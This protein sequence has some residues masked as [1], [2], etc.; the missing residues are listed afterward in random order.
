L[1]AVTEAGQG[2]LREFYTKH[3]CRLKT[4]ELRLKEIRESVPL[5][6]DRAVISASARRIKA[7]INQ[8]KCLIEA[9]EEFDQEIEELFAKHPDHDLFASFPGAGKVLAPRLSAAFGTDRSRYQSADDVQKLSGVAP[10]TNRSGN[11][12]WVHRRYARPRFLHQTFVEFAEQSI[13]Q[14]P[15]AN[16]FYKLRRQAGQEHFAILRTLAFKWQRII[17]RCW[18][19]RAPYDEQTYQMALSRAGSP[20]SRAILSGAAA[21]V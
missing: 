16:A 12:I 18:I 10:V 9:I 6:T 15:W 17:F 21:N 11:S 14:S 19:D 20:L 3:R 7:T 1:E 4:I 13:I 5:T 2:A 8:V